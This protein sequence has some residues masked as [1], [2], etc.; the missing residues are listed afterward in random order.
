MV[1]GMSHN[2][3]RAHTNLL[4]SLW[5]ARISEWYSAQISFATSA[6]RFENKRLVVG[7]QLSMLALAYTQLYCTQ[8]CVRCQSFS[9]G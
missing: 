8:Y 4:A 2:R 9:L 1:L 3:S 5:S 6:P 7:H